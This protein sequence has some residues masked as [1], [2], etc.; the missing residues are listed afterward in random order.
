MSHN[1]NNDKEKIKEFKEEFSHLIKEFNE[2]H[3]FLE[4]EIEV[5]EQI[6]K[7][8]KKKLDKFY[9]NKFYKL[10]QKDL[11]KLRDKFLLIW[12]E[13][14]SLIENYLSLKKKHF[15]KIKEKDPDSNNERIIKY[16]YITIHKLKGE[17]CFYDS[18]IYG[19]FT[20]KDH[21]ILGH[22]KWFCFWDQY[23]LFTKE[24]VV[25]SYDC[26]EDINV[27][28]NQLNVKAGR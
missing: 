5:L 11:W 10:N 23:C 20:L 7:E 22:I 8:G 1:D 25:F 14:G 28:I 26:L 21:K 2:R 16:D 19:I 13:S 9:E 6:K 18:D 24:N 27:F 17:P 3:S 15:K 12:Y 4:R